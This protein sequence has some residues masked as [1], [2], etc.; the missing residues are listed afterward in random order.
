MY[1][2]FYGLASK[3]FQLNPDPNFFFGSINDGFFSRRNHHIF[4]TNRYT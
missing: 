3:P 2:A 1:E 4:H